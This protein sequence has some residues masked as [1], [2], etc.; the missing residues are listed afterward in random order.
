MPNLKFYKSTTEPTDA[1][2]GSI[3]FSNGI[4]QIKTDSGWETVANKNTIEHILVGD[5]EYEPKTVNTKKNVVC[6]PDNPY[7]LWQGDGH[8]GA[9]NLLGSLLVSAYQAS[10]AGLTSKN[11]ELTSDQHDALGDLMTLPSWIHYPDQ[12]NEGLFY[13]FGDPASRVTI[14]CIPGAYVSGKLQHNL[15]AITI[16][17]ER[18]G[19][20]KIYLNTL[21]TLQKSG[22]GTKFLNDKGEYS[23]IT[24]LSWT[25]WS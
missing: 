18:H 14:T 22:D 5:K 10:V 24:T 7:E 8:D 23:S 6:L 25:E 21:P 19:E 11:I 15:S 12:S 2:L 16:V 9:Y 4:L 1:E 17:I 13:C 20:G 3:W